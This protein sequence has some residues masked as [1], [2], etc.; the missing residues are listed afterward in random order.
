MFQRL[1]H[2]RQD[3]RARYA[4][5]HRA[6]HGQAHI[7]AM[8]ARLDA[9]RGALAGPD[10]VELA[11][12]FHDAVYDPRA[13]DNEARSAALLRTE[14]GGFLDAAPL[15]RAAMMILATATHTLPAGL[16]PDLER[17]AAVLLD[18][19]LAVLGAGAAVYDEYERGIATEYVP[20]HGVARFR[21][22]RLAFLQGVLAKPRIFIT[23]AAHQSMDAAARANIG[24]AMAALAGSRTG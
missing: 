12:W 9:D 20:V 23:E 19:D 22:G 15:D 2:V 24:R 7:D 3:L 1:D 17:D 21:A 18:L 13:A 5:P 11:V 6:Y 4:E 8:L 16:P 14:L 10:A